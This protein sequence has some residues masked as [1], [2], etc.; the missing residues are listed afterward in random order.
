[1]QDSTPLKEAMVESDFEHKYRGLRQACEEI[2][3]LDDK[4]NEVI[5]QVTNEDISAE[6]AAILNLSGIMLTEAMVEHIQA[7]REL[8]R[9]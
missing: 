8:V 2:L 9:G 5:E 3:A 7:L 1:M 6:Q 4:I